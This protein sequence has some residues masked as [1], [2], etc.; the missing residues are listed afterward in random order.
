VTGIV[1]TVLKRLSLNTAGKAAVAKPLL[2]GS[3]CVL[4]SLSA[5]GVRD[6]ARFERGLGRC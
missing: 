3:Q 5:L 1:R 2:L 4:H 6:P